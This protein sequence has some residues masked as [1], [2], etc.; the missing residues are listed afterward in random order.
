MQKKKLRLML[1]SKVLLGMQ[2]EFPLVQMTKSCEKYLR[3]SSVLLRFQ[4][5]LHVTF[6]TFYLFYLTP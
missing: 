4:L 6:S 2:S 1:Y 5:H 3:K